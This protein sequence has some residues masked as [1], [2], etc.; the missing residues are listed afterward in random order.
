MAEQ[1]ALPSRNNT[2]GGFPELRVDAV[3]WMA[4]CGLAMAVAYHPYFF[5]DEMSPLRDASAAGSFG[6]ALQVISLYK[7]R[8]LFNAIWAYG[9][10]HEWPRWAFGAI[11]AVAMMAIGALAAQLARRWFAATR[12]QLWLLLGCILLSR[13]S[14]MVYFDYVSGIIETLSFACFLGAVSLSDRAV[15]SN[16]VLSA[17]AAVAL[18]TAAVLVH[19]RYIAGTFALGCVIALALWVHKDL[20]RNRIAWLL[21]PGVALVPGAIFLSLVALMHSL[22]A[23]TGTSGQ[24]VMLNAGTLKVFASYLG[25]A[26]LGLNFGRPWFVGALTM[27]SRRGLLVA[28]VAAC[29]FALAWGAFIRSLRCDLRAA[30]AALGLLMLLGAM[31]VMASLPGEGR[32]EARWMYPVGTLVC[33][34]ALASPTAWVRLVLLLLTLGLGAVHWASGS[35]DQTANVYVSR[36]AR[37]LSEGINT[38][39]PPGRNALL[40]GLGEDP[41]DVG[42][43]SGVQTFAQRNFR[44]PVNMQIF[45]PARIEEQR[46]WADLLVIRS[47]VDTNQVAHFA[48]VNGEVMHMILDPE[49]IDAVRGQVS[50]DALLGGGNEGWKDWRWSHPAAQADAVTASVGGAERREGFREWPAPRLAGKTVVYRARSPGGDAQMRLQ[51]NWMGADGHFIGASIHVVHPTAEWQEFPMLMDVPDGAE[52]GLVYASVHDGEQGVVEIEQIRLESH[53]VESL[54]AGHAWADWR[55][56]GQPEVTDEGVVLKGAD[57]VAGFRELAVGTVDNKLLVY[58][59]RTLQP[60]ASAKLRLQ[61]NWMDRNGLFLGASIDAVSVTSDSKNH[62]IFV[63]APAA[64]ASALVY[65][66]LHDGE[67]GPVLL[68]SVDVVGLP[69]K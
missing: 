47:V 41:W 45:D 16:G 50:V 63:V 2:G 68:E 37:N 39:T 5:G 53:A 69:R 12:L 24:E 48:S 35:L 40:Y 26:F 10:V 38:M 36:T 46:Q 30:R 32:Q 65:A 21:V 1:G 34:L 43:R 3:L 13:F 6:Q 19:E 61:V 54:G 42:H 33:L 51:V 52:S 57:E 49:R 7:P 15:R 17:L 14:A 62:A 59:A 28:V 8:L 4:L 20:R 64:A 27:D 67:K 25:N 23:S 58:R 11:N 66:N 9:G 44:L 55:W 22:P 31:V 60:G 18:A 29:L 56:Q